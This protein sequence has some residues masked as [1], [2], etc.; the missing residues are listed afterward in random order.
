MQ[1]YREYLRETF[2]KRYLFAALHNTKPPPLKLTYANLPTMQ[3]DA[4]R[5]AVFFLR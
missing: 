3:V 5:D 4:L 2:S 1:S